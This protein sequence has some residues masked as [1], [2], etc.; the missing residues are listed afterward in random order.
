MQPLIQI[1]VIASSVAAISKAVHPYT[2]FALSWT[3]SVRI[4]GYPPPVRRRGSS[5]A[6]VSKD[7]LHQIA[8]ELGSS[9]H[10]H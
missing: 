4:E 10:R 2:P 9:V 5:A 6:P 1:A 8:A 7:I 3:Q